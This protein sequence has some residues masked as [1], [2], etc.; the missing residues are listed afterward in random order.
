M[1]VG[2]QLGR[3]VIPAGSV[4][5]VVSTEGRTGLRVEPALED[6]DGGDLVDHLTPLLLR[7]VDFAQ[8]A[9]RGDGGEALVPVD[10]GDTS[11]PGLS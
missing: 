4:L 10:D 8:R 9:V 11:N 5:A 1:H 2:G 7:G 6:E 3:G